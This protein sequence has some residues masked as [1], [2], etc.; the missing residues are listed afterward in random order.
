ML[1]AT[2]ASTMLTASTVSDTRTWG[3]NDGA[4][5]P[6]QVSVKPISQPHST[7]AEIETVSGT[8]PMRNPPAS[9]SGDSWW[10]G[11]VP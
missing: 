1:V 8:L 7:N 11:A 2:A 5:P 3:R 6:S 10:C 4:R 9:Q